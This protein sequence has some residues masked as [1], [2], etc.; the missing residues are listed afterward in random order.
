M[1]AALHTG[2][3]VVGIECDV[4]RLSELIREGA[5][6]YLA[7]TAPHPTII[8]RVEADRASFPTA[9]WA[10]LTRDAW[11][12]NGEVVVRDVCTSGLD[13]YARITA[14][15]PELVF[16]WRPPSTTRAAGAVLPARARLLAR[17][18]LLQYPALWWAGTRERVPLHAS[19]VDTGSKVVLLAGP[20]GVGKSTLVAAELDAG[21]RAT[22]DNLC[23]T[24]G[25]A[26][27]GVVEPLRFDRAEGRRMTHG[28]REARLGTRATSLLP[29]VV[30]VLRRGTDAHP[31]VV[32][33]DSRV[34]GRALAAGTY[35]AGELRRFWPF[36][37]TLAAGTGM[38]PVHPP[39]AAL[40][41]VLA[42][43]AETFEVVLARAPG[44]RLTQL[45][46]PL[47]EHLAWT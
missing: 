27:W 2:G 35:M 3:E 36:A 9:G 13:M 18:V 40:A 26:A 6:D 37:A 20:S 24:D 39:V 19:V 32:P 5:D 17:C 33:C 15:V 12:R 42:D 11:H 47:E 30:A 41:R 29:T 38:G 45:L 28:R 25:Y 1:R 43:R 7:S 46:E 14:G 10:V 34:A 8:V 4:P 44:A 21:A 16:R 23:V 31:S 22:S